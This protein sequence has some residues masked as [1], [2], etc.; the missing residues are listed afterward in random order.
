MSF[1]VKMTICRTSS[2]QYFTTDYHKSYCLCYF[3]Q[4]VPQTIIPLFIT[5]F[6]VI[7]HIS[8]VCF[9]F[10]K[11]QIIYTIPLAYQLYSSCL[12]SALQFH[13]CGF[14]YSMCVHVFVV[15]ITGNTKLVF[16]QNFLIRKWHSYSTYGAH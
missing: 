6:P 1:Q 14:Q 13:I 15:M 2:P 9:D 11:K 4:L 7:T 5:C 3:K 12:N 10:Y 8:I 16:T